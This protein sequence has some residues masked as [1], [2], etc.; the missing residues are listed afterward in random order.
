MAKTDCTDRV[1]GA[2]LASWR[3]DIS[4]ISPEM[5]KDYE[6]HFAD[7]TRC[8]SRLKFHRG[9]DVAL[10]VLTSLSVFFSLFA[11]AALRHVKPLEH[12]AFNVLGLDV[13]DAYHMLVS[14]A[15]AGVLFS[16][17]AFVLVLTA[18]PVP[19]YLGG[20]AAERARLLEERFPEA[21][22]RLPNAI[23]SLRPR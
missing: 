11:L 12:V 3:Y 22:E 23:K 18:T 6:Q 16:V 8:S 1:V 7:C 9:L 20:I 15:V 13:A 14:A 17:I 19:S 2:I 10:V 21:M 5:R 4:G